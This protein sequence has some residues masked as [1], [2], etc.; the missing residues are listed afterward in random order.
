MRDFALKWENMC[1]EF[2]QSEQSSNEASRMYRFNHDALSGYRKT[3]LI[4]K[5]IELPKYEFDEIL[6]HIHQLIISM[7]SIFAVG[8]YCLNLSCVLVHRKENVWNTVSKSRGK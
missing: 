5:D 7:R 6:E 4:S 3:L 2:L 8:G 1:N